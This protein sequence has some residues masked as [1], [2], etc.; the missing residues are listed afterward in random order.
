MLP[1]LNLFV[2]IVPFVCFFIV[3][4]APKMAFVQKRLI[5]IC[6]KLFEVETRRR[7]EPSADPE[8]FC[9]FLPA[10]SDGAEKAAGGGAEPN[11]AHLGEQEET[12]VQMGDER[13]R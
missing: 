6:S 13:P 2:C 4:A 9:F 3:R 11:R 1:E 8:C 5:S 12:G 10:G 7:S